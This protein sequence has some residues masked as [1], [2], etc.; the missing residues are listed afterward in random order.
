LA[1][2]K[3]I[4]EKEIIPS[5]VKKFGYKNS[6]MVPRVKK[7][8]LNVG[9]GS[10]KNDP[11]SLESAKK[12]LALISGQQPVVTRAKRSIAGFNLRE[13]TPIGCKVTMRGDRMYEFLDRLF[14]LA[15]PRIKDFQGISLDQF[16]SRGNFTLGLA[17]QLVFPEISYD[18]VGVIHGL[19]VAI[20][21]TAVNDEEARE[22]L[23]S[24][25][26]PFKN[27]S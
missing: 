27:R 5:M 6:M 21:T 13:N 22:L 4:Y 3:E 18:E 11:K 19:S 9:V 1:R 20:V 10:A 26:L 17:E 2:L 25:G 24:L 7:V 15:I 8:C 23:T 14:N 12:N 16:D